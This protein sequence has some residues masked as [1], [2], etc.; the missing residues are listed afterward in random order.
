MPIMP[1]VIR[2]LGAPAPK[3]VEGTMTGPATAAPT[4]AAD[5]NRKSRRLMLWFFVID[6]VSY[7]WLILV[8]L[9]RLSASTVSGSPV[10]V[11]KGLHCRQ[12]FATI[13]GIDQR[14]APA[15]SI[16]S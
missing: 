12:H 16:C 6:Q 14:A 13:Q 5:A 9:S 2:L 7:L 15:G 4:A 11:Y 8:V 10:P 3:T 1:M